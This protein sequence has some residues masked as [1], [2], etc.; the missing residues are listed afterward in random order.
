METLLPYSSYWLY[1]HGLH[2]WNPFVSI[3]NNHI[4]T[5]LNLFDLDLPRLIAS[6][7]YHQLSLVETHLLYYH[8]T[9]ARESWTTLANIY[10]KPTRRQINLLKGQL[11]S[12]IKVTHSITKFMQWIKCHTDDPA[13][14]NSLIY[15]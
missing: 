9:T 8:V 5:N 3:T 4:E 10:V 11:H 12:S 14:L 13:L 15:I 2:R 7:R 6:Q 1:Y